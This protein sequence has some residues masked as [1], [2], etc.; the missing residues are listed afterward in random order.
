[1]VIIKKEKE[2]L[3]NKKHPWLYSG[4]IADI[5]E[6]PENGDIVPV[7]TKAGSILCYG[8]YSPGSLITVRIISFG[9]KE[10]GKN[11]IQA[12]IRNAYVL[13]KNLF[14]PSNSY[15]LINAEGDFIPGLIVDVYNKTI[16]VC[17]LI[18]G[19]EKNLGKIADT[20]ADL[21]PDNKIFIKRDEYSARKENI[22]IKNGYYKGTGDGLETIEEN[23][24]IFSVNIISG[25]KTGFYLDQR[26]A[27]ILFSSYCLHKAV[28]NL[29]SYTGAFSLHAVKGGAKKV[30]SVEQ[31]KKAIEFAV[32]N[33]DNN[34]AYKTTFEWIQDDVFHFLPGSGI[35]DVIVCDPPPFARKKQEVKGAFKG[36]SFLNR[37]ALEHL[38]ENGWL[39]TFSCSSAVNR[40]L[41]LKTLRDAAV[42]AGRDARIIRELHSSPDHPYSLVHPEGEYLKGWAV[43][44]C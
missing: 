8:F 2:S 20:L 30:I 35:Y 15:R 34:P 27:R 36:Y 29:F 9:P 25:Q 14:I 1:M 28:L 42:L 38:S 41:F 3:I 40:E 6:S 4:A 39:F 7:C 26:D 11:W 37:N 13:R 16:V 31:S 12:R 22:S 44:V 10:P 17:P 21:F 43:Y 32:K 19:I 5:K 33:V 23:G 24:L 18:K